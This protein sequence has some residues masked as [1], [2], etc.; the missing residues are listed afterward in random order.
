MQEMQ[1]KEHFQEILTMIEED[2]DEFA[3][4]KID[5]VGGYPFVVKEHPFRVVDKASLS[6]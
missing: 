3:L 6:N 1:E 4:R 5:L 2:E